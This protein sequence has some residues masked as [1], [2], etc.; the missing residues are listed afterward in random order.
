MDDDVH[1][2]LITWPAR[3][4]R[5]ER[6]FGNARSGTYVRYQS[7]LGEANISRPANTVTDVEIQAEQTVWR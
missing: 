7:F 3:F 2:E 4:R 6:T 5:S 1:D